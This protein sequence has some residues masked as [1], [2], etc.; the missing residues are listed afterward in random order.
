MKMR[1]NVRDMR[2]GEREESKGN[3]T[4]IER[5]TKSAREGK[6]GRGAVQCGDWS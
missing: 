6:R 5:Q 4:K 1:W 2:E 3:K